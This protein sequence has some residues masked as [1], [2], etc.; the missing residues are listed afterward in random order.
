[1]LTETGRHRGRQADR[2]TDT[3]TFVR[4]GRGRQKI[5]AC[6][7]ADVLAH[8]NK[9]AIFAAKP[10]TPELMRAPSVC[11]C[12]LFHVFPPCVCE[13]RKRQAYCAALR[14]LELTFLH[15]AFSKLLRRATG[16]FSRSKLLFSLSMSQRSCIFTLFAVTVNSPD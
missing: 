6:R 14:F 1:M 3:R 15:R 2:Q 13:K 7:H 9:K 10:G 16:M 8:I 12:L 5:E 11:C 4:T